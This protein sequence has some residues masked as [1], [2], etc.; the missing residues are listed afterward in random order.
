METLIVVGIIFLILV[1]A[2]IAIASFL[3]RT[4]N[5]LVVLKNSASTAWAQVETE[6]QLR[7]DLVPA[8]VKSVKGYATHEKETLENV[9]KARSEAVNAQ[10]LDQAME[11]NDG[12]T[13]ALS[14]LMMLIENYPQLKADAG[15]LRLQSQLQ[16]IEG[17][18][19]YSRRYFN[20]SVRIYNT[21][22]QIFPAN[23]VAKPFGH[24]DMKLFK[25]S[26]EAATPP[27]FDF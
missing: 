21:A 18:I 20:E 8:I 10:G 11:A 17:S 9:I 24:G 12:L 27:N 1:I 22:Q 2:V 23:L 4:Y 16:A 25:S 14:K 19:N 7:L 5:N 26:P 15:F 3:W 13:N 6:Y